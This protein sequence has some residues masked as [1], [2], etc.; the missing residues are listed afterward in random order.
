MK[1]IWRILA[2]HDDVAALDHTLPVGE[3]AEAWGTPQRVLRS[4]GSWMRFRVGPGAPVPGKSAESLP[5]SLWVAFVVV[6]GLAACSGA[7]SPRN[8]DSAEGSDIVPRGPDADDVVVDATGPTEASTVHDAVALSGLDLA[9]AVEVG[10]HTPEAAGA[11][12]DAG[13]AE[14]GEPDAGVFALDATDANAQE[15]SILPDAERGEVFG[16]F[17]DASLDAGVD[18]GGAIDGGGDSGGDAEA[19]MSRETT[20]PGGCEPGPCD[21]D[22]ADSAP[23]DSGPLPRIW[24]YLLAGQ[25]NMVGLG[26]NSDL[27]QLESTPVPDSEIYDDSVG[28]WNTHVGTWLAIGPGCGAHDDQFGPELGFARRFREIYPD[29]RLAIIK[30]GQGGTGLY[31]RW[32]APTG[33]LYQL[34]VS[35][36]RAQLAVLAMR[37]RP[38]IA[39][40]IWMQGEADASNRGQALAYR[41]NLVDFVTGLRA[42][43]GVAG[44]PIVAGLIAQDFGWPYADIVRDSTALVS[45]MTGQME[46]VET[47][48]QPMW[49]DDLAHYSSAGQ[50][51]IGTRFA[52]AAARLLATRWKFPEE[53]SSVQGGADFTYREHSSGVS[54]ELVFDSANQRWAGD[55][56]EVCIGNGSMTPG[57]ASQAELAWWA[58]FA[59]TVSIEI[60]ASVPDAHGDGTTV[61]LASRSGPLWGPQEIVAGGTVA[62]GFS[63]NVEQGDE[64]Y[65]RT[66][67]GPPGDASH[68]TTSWRID[69]GTIWVKRY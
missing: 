18:A 59:A 41:Q 3:L 33:D 14:G 9:Q 54:T 36:V 26:E 17:V 21:A 48:D 15:A 11:Q 51:T 7:G 65:F 6:V 49:P 66:S 58:P 64:L 24:V 30:L 2:T 20:G 67:S 8:P 45:T 25:S 56:T 60:Q 55:G 35:T 53:F 34:M 57:I 27:T 12:A 63:I 44:M 5:P 13:T 42:D 43:L 50:L 69:I 16:P 68:D 1:G 62:T 19:W 46:V 4:H 28:D 32:K 10:G 40:F 37:G 22:A 23:S 39:G 31:D 52:D 38:Q 47:D 61:E 29:R